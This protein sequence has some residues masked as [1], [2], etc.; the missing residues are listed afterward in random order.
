MDDFVGYIIA[1]PDRLRFAVDNALP[2]VKRI[3]KDVT[4]ETHLRKNFRPQSL[5]SVKIR[6]IYACIDRHCFD[7]RLFDFIVNKIKMRISVRSSKHF[8]Q[9]D[10]NHGVAAVTRKMSADYAK[11][12]VFQPVWKHPYVPK[13]LDGVNVEDNKLYALI[14]TLQHELIHALIFYCNEHYEAEHHGPKF[15]KLNSFLFG[16]SK[17]VFQYSRQI[18]DPII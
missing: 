11:I 9:R 5:T 4:R 18:N 12:T 16:H 6:S 14:V 10:P 3:A 8:H 7:G 1:I 2:M 15:L 13:R 17:T